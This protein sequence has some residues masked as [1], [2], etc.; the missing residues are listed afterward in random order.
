MSV[1]SDEGYRDAVVV[2][3]SELVGDHGLHQS[4]RSRTT[5]AI[6]KD[7]T[8][9]LRHQLWRVLFFCM[10]DELSAYLL[11]SVADNLFHLMDATPCWEDLERLFDEYRLLRSSLQRE[12]EALDSI[13]VRWEATFRATRTLWQLYHQPL[14]L[15]QKTTLH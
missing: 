4:V 13:M 7:L 2:V 15:H 8:A 9:G 6:L 11:V 10:G 1:V 3:T 12:R 5:P 14:V